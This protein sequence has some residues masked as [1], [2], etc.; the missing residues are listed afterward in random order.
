MIRKL[1]LLT[2][3]LFA[4]YCSSALSVSMGDLELQSALNQR[5][6]AEIELKNVGRLGVE[7]ILP[8]LASLDD[9]NRAG[10]ERSYQLTDLRFKVNIR[11]DGTFVILVTST[12]PI[13]EP[14]L[15]FIVE[16]IWPTG[17][18]LREYTVLLDPPV[19]GTEGIEKI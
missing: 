10:V 4:L 13:I 19:F 3:A 11:E 8:N 14:F 18:I 12:K 5:F 15:N 9:F 6:E 16:V 1:Q 17:R 2:A 7:E